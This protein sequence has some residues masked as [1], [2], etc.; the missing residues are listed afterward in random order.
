MMK[1]L[2]KVTHEMLVTLRNKIVT[3]QKVIVFL[4][5]KNGEGFSV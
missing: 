2:L 1:G 3:V 5:L 4:N